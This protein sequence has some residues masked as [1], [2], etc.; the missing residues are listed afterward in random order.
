MKT[1]FFQ[2]E[3]IK[4]QGTHFGS[5]RVEVQMGQSTSPFVGLG[6]LNFDGDEPPIVVKLS[7]EA[8]VLGID[9]L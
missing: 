3:M 2:K 1:F 7:L 6:G 4:I 9:K 8:Y 5:T